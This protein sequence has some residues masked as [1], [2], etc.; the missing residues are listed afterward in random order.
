MG[1]GGFCGH[2]LH[3]VGVAAIQQSHLFCTF[4]NEVASIYH[5]TKIAAY[6]VWKMIGK[7]GVF[8][9]SISTRPCQI[10]SLAVEYKSSSS[11]SQEEQTT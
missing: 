11:S 7:Y 9:D 6:C 1:K 10:A 3:S 5:V 8:D 4:L 2:W